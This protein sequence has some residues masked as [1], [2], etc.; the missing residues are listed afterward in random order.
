[1]RVKVE[2]A[3]CTA[4]SLFP[5][6]HL[7]DH[8]PSTQ[9]VVHVQHQCS[10]THPHIAF[11]GMDPAT[12]PLSPAQSPSP[13]SLEW[14]RSM[15]SDVPERPY[16]TYDELSYDDYLVRPRASTSQPKHI[17][18]RLRGLTHQNHSLT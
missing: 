17:T 10:E 13:P 1:M 16:P 6:R 3:K 8:P 11:G 9:T 2:S 7:E 4:V 12:E 14:Q 18:R 5:S 15:T